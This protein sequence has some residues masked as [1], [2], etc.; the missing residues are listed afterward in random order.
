SVNNGFVD[1]VI[2]IVFGVIGWLMKKTG[3]DPGPLVLAFVLGPI[4]EQ[5]FRQSMLLSHVSARIFM[6]RPLSGTIIFVILLMIHIN[7]AAPLVK[8]VR[9]HIHRDVPSRD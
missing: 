3:F 2:V 5:A 6:S 7:V 8:R 1:M 9:V 4:L